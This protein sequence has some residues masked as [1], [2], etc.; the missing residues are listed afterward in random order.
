MNGRV[1]NLV[2]EYS[3]FL[4]YCVF[5]AMATGVNMLSYELFYRILGWPNVLST[6]LSWLTAV[7]FAFVTN[8]LIVFRAKEGEARRPIIQ[9]LG[10]FYL[11]RALSGVLDIIVMFI[12][13]DL[14][15]WNHTLW[16]FISNLLMGL[17]NYLAGKFLI[18]RQKAR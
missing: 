14:M 12:A 15:A 9:E 7:S 11:C 16:K 1:I 18:F 13:V 17:C 5:G 10:F 6:A 2:R 3:D 4:T 8:R